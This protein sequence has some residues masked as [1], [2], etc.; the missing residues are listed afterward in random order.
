[1]TASM[2]SSRSWSLV[3]VLVAIT[4]LLLLS[5]PYAEAAPLPGTLAFPP[6]APHPQ[7]GL[8]WTAWQDLGGTLTS[9][10]A[11][12]SWGRERITV[13]A[14]GG[15]GEII[16]TYKEG[17][18]AWTPWRTPSELRGVILRSA[19][20]CASWTSGAI[21][22]VALREGYGGVFQFYWN[23]RGW[24]TNDLGGDATSAPAIVAWGA[25]RL[26][27]FVRN[28]N[29]NL[30]HRYWQHNVTDWTPPRWEAVGSGTITSAPSCASREVGVIDCFAL[31]PNGVVM[32]LYY[33]ERAGARWVGWNQLMGM[34]TFRATSPISAV[35]WNRNLLDLFARGPD[36]RLY[37]ITYSG[38]WAEPWT[39]ME[40]RTLI[41]APSCTR[42][43]PGRL[44][45]F[46]QVLDPQAQNT[47]AFNVAPGLAY[48]YAQRR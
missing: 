14:R 17:G 10:P 26:S 8:T 36:M 25:G 13:F 34:A 48:R 11:A 5:S 24:F 19:P 33:D 40:E 27:V 31:G 16:Q 18:N 7:F 42:V 43:E 21:N 32:Q 20:S 12:V 23:G 41:G 46:A 38:T 37:Q 9:A 44:D 1:M 6:T 3:V 39:V 2:R 30:I 47:S 28:S 45:C 4:T 22:C 29:G 15:N 35:G